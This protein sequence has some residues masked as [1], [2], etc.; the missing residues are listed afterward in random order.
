MALLKRK[1]EKTTILSIRVPVS[2]KQDIETL[3]KAADEAGFDLV[4]SLADAVI[5]WTRQVHDELGTAMRI[6][7]STADKT[8]HTNGQH[9][10]D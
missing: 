6:A 3:R 8:V 5:K 1:Q 2:V 10:D 7:H 9:G 4:G